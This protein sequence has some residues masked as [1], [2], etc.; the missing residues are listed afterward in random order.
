MNGKNE[1]VLVIIKFGPKSYTRTLG[2][3]LKVE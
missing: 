2:E 3:N 1:E